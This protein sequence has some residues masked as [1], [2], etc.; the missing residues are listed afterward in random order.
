MEKPSNPFS[1][2]LGGG[3]TSGNFPILKNL[4]MTQL[5]LKENQLL[6][7]HLHP[8][9]NELAYFITGTAEVAV[10]DPN[11]KSGTLVQPFKVS[12]GDV[13]FFPQ[14]F[15]HYVNN[16]GSD[17]VHFI[18]TFDNPDFDLEFVT[19]LFKA[20]KAGGLPTH[21]W[22]KAFQLEDSTILSSLQHGGGIVPQK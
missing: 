3:V 12:A 19:D 21:I 5:T 18:L 11:A 16:I 9:A 10:F 15:V 13:V 14:G 2:P 6:T 4:G 1:M 17:D 8:N 22:Q 7:P 20:P